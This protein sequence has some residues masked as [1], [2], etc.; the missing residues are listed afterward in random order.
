MP[1]NPSIALSGKSIELESPVNAMAQIMQL[2]NVQQANALNQ[3][4]MDEAR[5]SMEEQDALRAFLPSMTEGREIELLRYG[6]AGRQVYESLLKGRKDLREAN[7]AEEDIAAARMQKW[8]DLLPSVNDPQTYAQW[9]AGATR[10]MPGIANMIPEQFSPEIR[11]SLM[12]TAD[13]ELEKYYQTRTTGKITETIV[14]PKYGFGVATAVPGSQVTMT[15]TPGEDLSATT[16]RRGQD[17]Q[18]ETTRRGQNL[19][20]ARERD[21]VLAESIAGARKRGQDMAENEVLAKRELP[22]VID[23]ANQALKNI[24]D[25]IGDSKVVNGKLVLGK[26]PVHPGFSRVVGATDLP[27]IR[28]VHGTPAADFQSRFDQIKGSSFL[29]AYETLKG[30][31]QITEIEGQKGTAA[32][33]RMGLAQ[34][35]AEFVQAANELRDVIRSGVARARQ[36]TGGGSAQTSDPLGIR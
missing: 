7:K 18:A 5:R 13:K 22:K 20:E 34:S 31:G 17:I 27:G 8:R 3:M 24:D 16:Q 1:I 36:K 4:K 6:G 29:Q 33:N 15:T 32:I 9:R 19:I 14:M 35:E 23:T 25:M 12:L 21:V 11:Q 10:E 28:F 2:K 26:K 30:G